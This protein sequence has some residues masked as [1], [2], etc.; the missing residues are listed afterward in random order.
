MEST[1]LGKPSQIQQEVYMV[2]SQPAAQRE[3]SLVLAVPAHYDKV[4]PGWVLAVL[5][6][7]SV[8]SLPQ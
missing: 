3:V 2:L 8:L 4:T 5:I 1:S 6:D 7:V